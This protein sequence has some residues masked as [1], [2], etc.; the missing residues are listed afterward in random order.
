[1]GKL[2]RT[3][4]FGSVG[5]DVEGAT[6]AMHRYLR[7]GQLDEFARQRD[8]VRRTFGQGKRTLAKRCAAKARLPQHGV[9]GPQLEQAMRTAGAFD[10]LADH[11]L[12]EYRRLHTPPEMA[13]PTGRHGVLCQGLHPTAGLAGNWAVDICCPGNTVVVAP[14]ECRVRKLSGRPPSQGAEQTVGIFGWSLHLE[15]VDGGYRYFL[16]HLGSRSVELAERLDPGDRVGTVGWWPNNPGRSH[17]H[18]GVTSP[19]GPADARKRILRIAEAGA[20]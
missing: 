6:R 2:T 16:T 8:S 15:T 1:M 7:T 4:R 17:L 13:H 14:E 9:V 3:L 11:L 18:I 12:D 19:Y 20:V 10:L 5:T